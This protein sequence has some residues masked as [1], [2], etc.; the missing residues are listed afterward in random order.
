MHQRGHFAVAGN[1]NKGRFGGRCHK[2]VLSMAKEKITKDIMRELF[3]GCTLLRI[4]A[5][6]WCY[7]HSVVHFRAYQQTNSVDRQRESTRDLEKLPRHDIAFWSLT[8][9]NRQR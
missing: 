8:H 7:L 6:V 2:A 4:P 3:D 1:G 9:V 5:P